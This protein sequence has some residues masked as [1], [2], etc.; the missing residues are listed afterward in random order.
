MPA[1][2]DNKG[3]WY[4]QF[5]YKDYKGKTK[6]T[7]KRGFR[8]KREALEYEKRYIERSRCSLNM[9]LVDFVEVYFSDKKM[10]LKL[11][12][13]RNKRYMINKYIIPELGEKEVNKI[14]TADI[15]NWQKNIS[16]LGLSE[17]YQRML[18]NQI[19]ALFTHAAKVYELPHNPCKRI[20]KIGKADAK[21][22][23][24]WTTEEFQQFISSFDPQDKYVVLFDMLFW[25]GL[26]IGEALAC[27]SQ[28]F[29]FENGI[30]SVTKTFYRMEGK[31]II[32]SPKTEGSIREVLLPDFLNA[33]IKEY[34]ERLYKYPKNQRIFPVTVRAVEAVMSRHIQKSGLRK[35]RLHDLRHSHASLLINNGFQ[36][37]AIAERLGHADVRMT[38]NKYSHLYPSEQ[39]RLAQ[40]LNDLKNENEI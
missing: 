28:D 21:H 11:Q 14:S 9:R 8:T 10:E 2:K 37:K 15:V 1:Y 24:Y 27:N 19:V 32:T 18:N 34:I 33:E 4:V 20:N 30:V 13:I 12:T 29:D 26:R 23:D 25:T 6:S 35:I 16:E 40:K 38:L 3:N 17:T 5:R 7:T 31:D 22:I 39:Q 36:P